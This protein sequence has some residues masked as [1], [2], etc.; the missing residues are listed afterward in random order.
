MK[1]EHQTEYIFSHILR[2]VHGIAG[3]E[4][5]DCTFVKNRESWLRS[6]SVHHTILDS[7][8]RQ[9]GVNIDRKRCILNGGDKKNIILVWR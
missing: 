2:I 4:K 3:I 9:L 6:I 5:F 7:E 1:K 8:G